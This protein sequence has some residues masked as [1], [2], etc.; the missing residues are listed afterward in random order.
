M[1]R[2]DVN[3]SDNDKSE[4]LSGIAQILRGVEDMGNRKELAKQQI[5]Q[6]KDEGI[7][8]DIKEFLLMCGFSGDM[9]GIETPSITSEMSNND[10]HFK[11]LLKIYSRGGMLKKAIS[12]YLFPTKS[13][14]SISDIAKELRHMDYDDVTQLEKKLR[15]DIHKY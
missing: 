11:Q 9:A 5:I 13:N 2:E 15:I 10:I 12:N 4:M 3:V 7:E 8:F 6:L 1:K 14:V